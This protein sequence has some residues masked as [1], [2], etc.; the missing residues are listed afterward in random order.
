MEGKCRNHKFFLLMI[1]PVGCLP[2]SIG[3]LSQIPYALSHIPYIIFSL[4]IFG[5]ILAYMIY[6]LRCEP[7]AYIIKEGKIQVKCLFRLYCFQ[8]REIERIV[9]HYDVFFEYLSIK[10]YVLYLDVKGKVPGRCWLIMK[11]KK[12]KKLIEKYFGEKI[13]EF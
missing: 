8:Y 13:R 3:L 4:F 1:L 12:T 9:V 2:L 11:N 7:V 10:D 6:L 5:I